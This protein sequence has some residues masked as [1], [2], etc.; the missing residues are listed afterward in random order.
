LAHGNLRDGD[1]VVTSH[2][3]IFYVV[4]YEHPEDRY[5]AILKYVPENLAEELGLDWV[6]IRWEMG[7]TTLYRPRELYSPEAYGRL[8][9]ALRCS[10]PDYLLLSER[11]GRWLVTV[12]RRL[13]EEVYVPSRQLTRIRRRGARDRFEERALE[14][15]GLLS[16]VAGVPQGFFGVHGSISL[17]SSH[18]GSDVDLSVYGASNFRRVKEALA[19]LEEEGRLTLSRGDRVDAKRLN[20]G[21][22]Q[23]D[24]FVINATRRFSEIERRRRTYRPLGP[25]E[26]ECTC[27]SDEEAVFRP[28]VYRVSGCRPLGNIRL[29]LQGVSEVVSMIGRQRSLVRPGEAMRARGVLEQ[30]F[31]GNEAVH[32]RVFV[33]SALP[34]EY[35]DW[36]D[37]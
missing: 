35:M 27:V 26:L 2:G 20:R 14:L 36:V 29:Q 8:I 1:A 6:D 33:G 4:G 24:R 31:E 28:A 9:E 12:P 7:G 11:L 21:V 5:H 3:L 10:Y 22:F 19:E 17:G 13:I 37:P 32:Y 25:V 15:I 16:K 30:V 34:G 23:G 18:E